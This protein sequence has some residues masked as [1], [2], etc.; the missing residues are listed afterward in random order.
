MCKPYLDYQKVN[1]NEELMIIGECK[2]GCDNVTGYHFSIFKEWNT[3]SA[4]NWIECT[5]DQTCI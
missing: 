2:E 1:P 3:G 4:T 5:S